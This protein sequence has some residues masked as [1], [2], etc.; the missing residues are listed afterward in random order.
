MRFHV[1]GMFI[2]PPGTYDDNPGCRLTF[3]DTTPRHDNLQ[4]TGNRSED[5]FSHSVQILKHNLLSAAFYRTWS[6]DHTTRARACRP[7][8]GVEA[9]LYKDSSKPEAHQVSQF[10]VKPVAFAGCCLDLKLRVLHTELQVQ[11][12]TDP[13]AS[14]YG[15]TAVYSTVC[16]MCL[17]NSSVLSHGPI[18]VGTVAAEMSRQLLIQTLHDTN[19]DQNQ[20]STY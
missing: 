16:C 7:H 1:D 19:R 12:R 18:A 11:S 4:T 2:S 17:A 14:M 3:Y 20:R 15:Y 6:F 8:R 10:Q 13:K 5:T 9:P